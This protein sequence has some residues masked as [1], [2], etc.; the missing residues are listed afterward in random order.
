MDARLAR[1]IYTLK[2]AAKLKK[3]N[4]ELSDVFIKKNDSYFPNKTDQQVEFTKGTIESKVKSDGHPD[5]MQN[6]EIKKNK[7][8]ERKKKEL[9]KKEREKYL[10]KQ[11]ENYVKNG[12][13]TISLD[14]EKMQT[15]RSI[16]NPTRTNNPIQ[17][18]QYIPSINPQMNQS[19]SIPMN[20][21]MNQRVMNQQINPQMNQQMFQKSYQYQ[22]KN[23]LNRI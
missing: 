1:V 7:I 5:P 6:I 15:E 13:N 22:Q 4:P 19:M 2:V 10:S 18:V 20:Q 16:N 11:F 3:N 21:Q 14:F 23:P 12:P 9:E 17:N 8:A